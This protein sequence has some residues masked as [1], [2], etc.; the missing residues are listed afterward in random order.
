MNLTRRRLLGALTAGGAVSAA[1]CTDLANVPGVGAGDDGDG[2]SADSEVVGPEHRYVEADPDAPFS[3]TL[4]GPDGESALFDAADIDHV[5]GVYEDDEEFL[6]VL[7][8]GADGLTRFRDGFDD[9]GVSDDPAA[10]AI[11]MTHDDEEVRRV[12]LDAGTVEALTD[13]TWGGVLTLPF[14]EEG[15][16]RDV[17]EGLAGDDPEP[18][19][20]DA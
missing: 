18:V 15:L 2:E 1:G 5:E 4:E 7:E 14:D 16:A 19:D 6:V 10:F 3:A 11:V 8:L 17:Y 9:A 12:D 20:E 13:E